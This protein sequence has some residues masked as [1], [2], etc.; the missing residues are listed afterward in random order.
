[1]FYLIRF[2]VGHIE[3]QHI[4]NKHGNRK[5]LYMI[6]LLIALQLNH[7][8]NNQIQLKLLIMLRINQINFLKINLH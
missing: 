2:Q 8:I 6:I 1:M 5:H 3:F 4:L 7:K